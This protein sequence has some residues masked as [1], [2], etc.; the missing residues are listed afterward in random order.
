MI[1]L[2]I[3]IYAKQAFMSLADDV[4]ILFLTKRPF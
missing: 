1:R 3:K 2:M 4:D